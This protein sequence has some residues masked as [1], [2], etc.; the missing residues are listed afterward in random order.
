MEDNTGGMI[1]LNGWCDDQ[2]YFRWK[3]YNEKLMRK[4]TELAPDKTAIILL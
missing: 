4:L 3:I 1:I 2:K